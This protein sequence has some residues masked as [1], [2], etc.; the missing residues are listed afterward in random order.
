MKSEILVF[1]PGR[2]AKMADAVGQKVCS[3]LRNELGLESTPQE[4]DGEKGERL[5]CLSI[6][7]PKKVS[8][9]SITTLVQKIAS[10]ACNQAYDEDS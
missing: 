8:D 6:M 4:C 7:R 3:K 9:R 10:Y 5:L 1:L 2:P